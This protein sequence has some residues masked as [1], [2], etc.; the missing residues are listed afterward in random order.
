MLPSRLGEALDHFL[1][2]RLQEQVGVE[3]LNHLVWSQRGL[4]SVIFSARIGC[5]C[6]LLRPFPLIVALGRIFFTCNPRSRRAGNGTMS[7]RRISVKE[8]GQPDHQGWLYRKKETKGFLGM[9]WKKY[10]FVL[11]KTSFY[12]Y[13]NQQASKEH[14]NVQ[15]ITI[16]LPV[17][18]FRVTYWSTV[19]SRARW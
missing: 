6:K 1:A 19:G 12:W 7:R 3:L 13:N 10:W 9:K 16:Q 8:L 15:S 11:K 5:F 17:A 4:L 14:L 18:V 2:E